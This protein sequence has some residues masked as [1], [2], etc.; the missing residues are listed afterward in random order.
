MTSTIGGLG[1]CVR[2]RDL[3]VGGGWQPGL[4]GR[5]VARGRRETRGGGFDACDTGCV[6]CVGRIGRRLRDGRR[7]AHR[8]G[9]SLS[10]IHI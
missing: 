7:R 8:T 5:R 6:G 10:L 2:P 3:R 1:A 9:R 4:L